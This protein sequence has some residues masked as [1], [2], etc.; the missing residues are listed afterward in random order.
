[1]CLAQSST[2]DPALLAIW[3][4]IFKHIPATQIPNWS[5]MLGVQSTNR[6]W[7]QCDLAVV[8]TFV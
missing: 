2:G 1:M 5:R 8:V 6:Q 4:S 3:R 7:N